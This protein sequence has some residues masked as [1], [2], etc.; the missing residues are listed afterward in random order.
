[1]V[2]K[3]KKK[4]IIISAIILILAAVI[5]GIIYIRYTK[6]KEQKDLDSRLIHI[7]GYEFKEKLNNKDSFMIIF[8]GTTCAH[9]HDF[10]PKF[11]RILKDY[12]LECYQIDI[13]TL[14]NEEQSYVKDLATINGTP[15]IVFIKDGVETSSYNRLVGDVGESKVIERLKV[16]GYIKK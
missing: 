12:N 3:V 5:S 6:E 1:M 7:N 9:C 8:T 10:L 15:T 4:I 11:K 14:N 2:I 13:D 16:M